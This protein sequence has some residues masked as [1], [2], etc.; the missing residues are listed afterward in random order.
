LE[1]EVRQPLVN[2]D[3]RV[4]GGKSRVQLDRA[5]ELRKPF[6][7]PHRFESREWIS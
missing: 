1:G 7:K 5:F 3:H 2:R 4:G 6:V